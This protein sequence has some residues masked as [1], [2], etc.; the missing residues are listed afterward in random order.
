M[1]NHCYNKLEIH[2]W[3]EE[4]PTADE[5]REAITSDDHPTIDFNKIIPMPE[6]LKHTGSGAK[7]FEIDGEEVRLR[8][9]YCNH[10]TGEERPFTE[11]EQAELDELGYTN[12]YNWATSNWDTK[13]NAY[14]DEVLD[15]HEES[16]VIS[17][18]TAWGPPENVIHKLREMFP[19]AYISGYYV[20]EGN[21]F[22]GVF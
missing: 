21:E 17:F 19:D 10:D 11:A 8:S 13:W 6:I 7:N 5:I 4:G 2:T 18:H 12:W 1:P 3:G 22:A 16:Y 15:L 9:W 14:D 20:G